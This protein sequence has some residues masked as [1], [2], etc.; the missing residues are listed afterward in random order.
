MEKKLGWFTRLFRKKIKLTYWINQQAYSA[1]VSD[2]KEKGPNCIIYKDYLTQK[3]TMIKYNNPIP[4]MLEQ[5][6]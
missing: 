4:Y 5:M 6:K 2:F 3:T 1:E